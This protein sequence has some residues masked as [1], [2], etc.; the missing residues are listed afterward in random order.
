MSIAASRDPAVGPPHP[1]TN[2]PRK[3]GDDTRA[4]IVDEDCRSIVESKAS[5]RRRPHVAEHAA[6]PGE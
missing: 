4:K 6:S 5:P 2:A 3:R 1:A